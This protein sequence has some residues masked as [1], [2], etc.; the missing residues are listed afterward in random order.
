MV[1]FVHARRGEQV[2]PDPD[3]MEF[4]DVYSAEEEARA[5]A[6]ELLAEAIRASR[7][8]TTFRTVSSSQMVKEISSISRSDVGAVRKVVGIR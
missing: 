6:R 5:A 1:Y 2:L 8:E 4:V 7:L 3:K